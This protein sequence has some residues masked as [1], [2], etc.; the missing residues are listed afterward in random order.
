MSNYSFGGHDQLSAQEL[1]FWIV[2]DTTL[3]RFGA[4]DVVAAVAVIAGQPMMATRGKLGG[5]TRGTSLASSMLARN[6]NVRLPFRLPTLTG[7]SLRT[8]RISFTSNLGRFVGRTIPVIGWLV[9]A[10]DVS[11]IIYRAVARYNVL[12]MREDKLW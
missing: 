7:A 1:F 8:L 2:V 3:D 6:L 9:L 11:S 4:Q 10:Y 5:A 12:A